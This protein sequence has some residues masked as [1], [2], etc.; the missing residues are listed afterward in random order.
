MPFVEDRTTV[1]R[2]L[3]VMSCHSVKPIPSIPHLGGE[4]PDFSIDAR[5]LG[6][7]CISLG[8]SWAYEPRDATESE[9]TNNPTDWDGFE[10]V[11]TKEDT[12][13]LINKFKPQ[14]YALL[15]TE[16]EECPDLKLLGDSNSPER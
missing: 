8:G 5:T 16:E 15:R 6:F 11:D 14:L 2:A 12:T 10:I 1:E 9:E 4:Y 7:L 3:I 13:I